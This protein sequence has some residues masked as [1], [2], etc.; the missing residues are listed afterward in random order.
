MDLK[1][2]KAI[3]TDNAISNAYSLD[4]I[5]LVSRDGVYPSAWSATGAFPDQDIVD[6]FV[7]S[8][9]RLF[10][11]EVQVI[12]P[13]SLSFIY[14]DLELAITCSVSNRYRGMADIDVGRHIVTVTSTPR[15]VTIVC[16]VSPVVYSVVSR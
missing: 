7:F 14:V 13:S 16:L 12:L 6:L 15:L 1:V 9:D 5:F 4:A 11:H 2:A 3:V 8:N 10:R